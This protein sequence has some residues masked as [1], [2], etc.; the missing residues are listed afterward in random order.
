M[1][2]DRMMQ[3]CDQ[4]TQTR[5]ISIRHDHCVDRYY[6]RLFDTISKR[7]VSY[8]FNSTSTDAHEMVSFCDFDIYPFCQGTGLI[9]FESPWVYYSECGYVYQS[10]DSYQIDPSAR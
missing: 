7:A 4:V 5:T 9:Y 8:S 6:G 10:G 3:P 2:S 1:A